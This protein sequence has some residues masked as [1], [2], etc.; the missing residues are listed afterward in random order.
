[1]V[2]QF[3]VCIL[4]LALPIVSFSANGKVETVQDKVS[5]SIGR[6]VGESIQKNGLKLD[7]SVLMSGVKD[8]I[9]GKESQ[10]TQ[11]DMA[12]VAA[13]MQRQRDDKAALAGSENKKEGEAFLAENGK[14]EGIKTLPSGLQYR[15]VKEGSGKSPAITDQVTVNYRGTLIDGTEFDSSYKRGKPATF[16]VGGVINGWTEAL[17]LMKEGSQWQLFIPA[18]LAYGERGAGAQVGPNAALVFDVTLIQIN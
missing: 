15:V 4:I 12:A 16:S 8:A 18:S 3:G 9:A 17:Q 13:E 14:K 10:L 11:E 5:Y 1:M 7:V 2:K 6:Q